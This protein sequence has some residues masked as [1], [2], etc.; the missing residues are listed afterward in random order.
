MYLDVYEESADG[1][2]GG[3]SR[4]LRSSFEISVVIAIVAMR[5][6]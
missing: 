5:R 6:S 2:V 3:R 1:G 4:R